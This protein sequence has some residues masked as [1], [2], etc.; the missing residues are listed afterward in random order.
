MSPRRARTRA[1]AT[2]S[3]PPSS[4]ALPSGQTS[5][6][7]LFQP[8]KHATARS[9]PVLGRELSSL[10][11]KATMEKPPRD[12]ARGAG[13][14]HRSHCSN[15]ASAHKLHTEPSRKPLEQL[16]AS[17]RPPTPRLPTLVFPH[18]HSPRSNTLSRQEKGLL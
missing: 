11:R 10:M 18:A 1:T 12:G 2:S 8:S 4:V 3:R 7:G 5:L 6:G 15:R 14:Q 17:R 16:E 9:A 13:W